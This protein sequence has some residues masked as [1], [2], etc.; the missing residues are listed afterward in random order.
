[1][2]ALVGHLLVTLLVSQSCKG[3]GEAAELAVQDAIHERPS[4]ASKLTP[5]SCLICSLSRSVSLLRQLQSSFKQAAKVALDLVAEGQHQELQ[6]SACALLSNLVLNFSPARVRFS[7]KLPGS[8][9]HLQP[10][11]VGGLTWGIR[12]DMGLVLDPMERVILLACC[13]GPVLAVMDSNTISCPAI[14]VSYPYKMC[15]L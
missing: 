5:L 1:M 8:C 7:A 14:Y 3:Q 11:V 15:P 10:H 13:R 12:E 9:L 4:G 2:P 6:V